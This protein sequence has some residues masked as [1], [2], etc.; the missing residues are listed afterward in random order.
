MYLHLLNISN[1]KINFLNLDLQIP[2][3]KYK[4]LKFRIPNASNQTLDFTFLYFQI[5]RFV[6]PNPLHLQLHLTKH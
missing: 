2:P 3:T 1:N 5:Q 6:T 4:I